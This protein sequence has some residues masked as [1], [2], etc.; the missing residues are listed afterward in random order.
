MNCY[1]EFDWTTPSHYF[2]I[3]TRCELAA[4]TTTTKMATRKVCGARTF[5]QNWI[6]SKHSSKTVSKY[7]FEISGNILCGDSCSIVEGLPVEFKCLNYEELYWINFTSTRRNNDYWKEMY[8]L[9][10]I[11]RSSCI[12]RDR[13]QYVQSVGSGIK[14][15]IGGQ[16][17][18]EPNND[19]YVNNCAVISVLKQFSLWWLPYRCLCKILRRVSL[20]IL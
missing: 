15:I 13:K 5:D 10:P 14:E 20:F 2:L 1:V 18:K 12:D 4:V 17:F 19:I 6:K 3:M 16:I 9:Y 7:Q 8:I 11:F